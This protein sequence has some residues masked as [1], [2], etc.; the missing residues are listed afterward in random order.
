MNKESQIGEQSLLSKLAN[1]GAAPFE[2]RAATALGISVIA[3]ALDYV[4]A[5]VFALP[6]IGDIADV[7][8]S[9][10]L[11]SITKSKKAAAINALEFI[12]VIG[13][14]IPAYTVSTLLWIHQESSKRKKTQER[15]RETT[16]ITADQRMTFGKSINKSTITRLGENSYYNGSS[17]LSS[18]RSD[19]RRQ[20]EKMRKLI[21]VRYAKWKAGKY[22]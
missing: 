12:P 16:I 22:Q 3:D 17:D 20:E 9:G 2:M 10:V 11:Y 8:V 14:F 1:I 6:V 5:P 21:A 18:K 7:F 15:T 13:D 4:A 19:D